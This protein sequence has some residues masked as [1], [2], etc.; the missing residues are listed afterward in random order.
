MLYCALII[1]CRIVATAVRH[2]FGLAWHVHIRTISPR[3]V[4]IGRRPAGPR[5]VRGAHRSREPGE[6]ASIA[7]TQT[8]IALHAIGREAE[9][10]DPGPSR[11]V[12][13]HRV[14]PLLPLLEMDRARLR[15]GIGSYEGL[16]RACRDGGAEGVVGVAWSATHLGDPKGPILRDLGTSR[17]APSLGGRPRGACHPCARAS[18]RGSSHSK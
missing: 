3:A 12:P 16:R 8:M 1:I 14:E 10:Y 18:V 7:T 17:R 9:A 4:I 13:F 2:Q 11:R 15:A 5:T 6:A